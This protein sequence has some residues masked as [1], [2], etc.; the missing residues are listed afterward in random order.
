MISVYYWSQNKQTFFTESVFLSMERLL[1][2]LKLEST[3]KIY[4]LVEVLNYCKK[5]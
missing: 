3:W 5:D 1:L 2:L 4:C